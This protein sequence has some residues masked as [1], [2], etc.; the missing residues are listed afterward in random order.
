MWGGVRSGLAVRLGMD[1]GEAQQQ[2]RFY[3]KLRYVRR[4]TTNDSFL[5][6]AVNGWDGGWGWRWGV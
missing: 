6:V 3:T 2:L 5:G 4:A 1:A